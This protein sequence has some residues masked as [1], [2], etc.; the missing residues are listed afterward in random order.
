MGITGIPGIRLGIAWGAAP[1]GIPGRMGI[2]VPMGIPGIPGIG[3]APGIE[4]DAPGDGRLLP[5]SC[6]PPAGDRETTEAA[7][8]RR[9]SATGGRGNLQAVASVVR[10]GWLS[11]TGSS[12]RGWRSS[13]VST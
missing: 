4:N 5:A 13:S 9:L 6:V 7:R 8:V 10:V 12:S 3:P 11:P 2:P 1:K